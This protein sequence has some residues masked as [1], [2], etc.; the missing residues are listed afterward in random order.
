MIHTNLITPRKKIFGKFS[1]HLAFAC[2]IREFGRDNIVLTGDTEGVEL[3]RLYDVGYGCTL[4]FKLPKHA[5]GQF[6]VTL[7]GQAKREGEDTL[8]DIEQDTAVVNYDTRQTIDATFGEPVYQNREIRIPI[9]FPENIT[10]LTK[11]H[12]SIAF[13]PGK[14]KVWLYGSNNHYELVLRPPRNKTGEITV[15]FMQQIIRD[16]GIAVSVNAS[17]ITIAYP[18]AA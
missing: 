1:L 3:T 14:G 7:I 18:K 11:Q 12:F 6:T 15:S 10:E 17:P 5:I 8:T 9:T 4:H 16:H 2:G 13:S